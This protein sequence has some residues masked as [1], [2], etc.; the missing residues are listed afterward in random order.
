MNDNSHQT[1][2]YFGFS[3]VQIGFGGFAD[4]PEKDEKEEGAERLDRTRGQ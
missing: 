3:W 1:G 2:T 4:P